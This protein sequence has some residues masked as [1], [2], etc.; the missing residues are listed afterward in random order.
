[1]AGFPVPVQKNAAT[2]LNRRTAARSFVEWLSRLP[3]SHLIATERSIRMHQSKFGSLPDG[4][5]AERLILTNKT[6]I[7]L[8]LTNYAAAILGIRVPDH[9]GNLADV[10]LGFDTLEG[11]LADKVFMGAIVGRFAN[12]IANARFTLDGAEYQL[13]AN[14]KH[15]TLHGGPN[16]YYKKLWDVKSTGDHSVTFAYLSRD[17][18]EGFPGNLSVEATYTL[19]DQNEVRI[20]YLATTDKA[21]VVNL[22]NHAYFNL[23]GQAKSDIL[24]QFL[25]LEADFFLP[26]DASSIP[27]GEIRPVKGTVFDFT[28]AHQIGERINSGDDQLKSANGYDQCWV[29]RKKQNGVLTRA[30]LLHDPSSGRRMEISTTEPGIQLYSGNFLDGSFTGKQGKT[31]PFRS[32]LCLET[33]HFP[34]SPNQA[35]FPSTVLRPK[36]EYRSSTIY[37]FSW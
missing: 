28:E 27:T 8:G 18:E 10:V 13:P 15:H 12:R 37:K 19:T 3:Q 11:Y 36:Q 17:G 33:Q 29:L 9:D 24:G 20:D 31:Y 32:A 35:H 26:T 4:R 1:M 14:N 30:A 16:G 21:T 7:E 5:T 34:D 22:T 6:G 23:N 2:A 25:N